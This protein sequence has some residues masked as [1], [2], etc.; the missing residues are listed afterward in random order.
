[1]RSTTHVTGAFCIVAMFLGAGIAQSAEFGGFGSYVSG[2]KAS[3]PVGGGA[4]GAAFD[5]SGTIL[6][7]V[8][9]ATDEVRALMFAPDFMSGT[10]K[11]IGLGNLGDSNPSDVVVDANGDLYVT[12]D[13]TA[14]VRKI[15]DPMGAAVPS[16][17]FTGNAFLG[18]TGDDDP[19]GIKIAPA[20][21]SGSL[22]KPGDL[23]LN[24]KGLD[25][26]N[27]NAIESVAPDG[28]S[29]AIMATWTKLPNCTLADASPEN[30]A[31]DH[32]N[33]I[34]YMAPVQMTSVIDGSPLTQ[35]FTVSPDGV[36]TAHQITMP[37]VAGDL[38]DNVQGIAVNP[39]DGSIW[40]VDD[41][42]YPGTGYEPDDAVYRID[43]VTFVATLEIDFNAEPGNTSQGQGFPNFNYS[44]AFTPDGRH[45]ILGDIDGN[46][47][48]ANSMMVFGI[49]PEP[50]TVLLLGISGCL[51]V[52]RRRRS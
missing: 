18:T 11:S 12:Y 44:M 4:T 27:I 40:V 49:V 7:Y 25:D 24:D 47:N 52:G 3:V 1:M 38:L 30:M 23:L 6:Y 51:L 20:G 19:F 15:T 10:T 17:V 9:D 35:V 39:L 43:P 8:S 28:S 45:L 41:D 26:N 21:Y 31:V 46:S 33:S 48:T 37:S 22:A 42:N 32:V 34:V 14:A 29:Y 5:A 50:T 2:F 16:N 36:L 13:F